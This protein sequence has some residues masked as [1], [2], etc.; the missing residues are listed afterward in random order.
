MKSPAA[1]GSRNPMR[2]GIDQALVIAAVG[3]Q[4]VDRLVEDVDPVQA[5]L[6]PAG[7]SPRV[8]APW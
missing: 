4:G 7:P 8:F 1:V 2:S 6:V 5:S 3:L